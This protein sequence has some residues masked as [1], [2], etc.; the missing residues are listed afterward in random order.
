L[1]KEPRRLEGESEE[2][3]LL[4]EEL[5]RWLIEERRRMDW[6]PEEVRRGLEVLELGIDPRAVHRCIEVDPRPPGAEPPVLMSAYYPKEVAVQVWLPFYAYIFRPFTKGE[7]QADALER[8]G[9]RLGEY[10]QRDEAAR[11][12]FAVGATIT[13]TPKL[14]GFQFNPPNLTIELQEDWHRLEFKLRAPAE[15]AGRASNGVLTFTA[16]GVIIADVPISIY[17]GERGSAAEM[18]VASGRPYQ[19]IFCSYSH[20]DKRVAK[21]VEAVCK[22]LGFTYHR[23]VMMLRSGQHWRDEIRALIE[24]ADIFQLFWSRNA[25]R[26]AYVEEEWRHALGLGR[27]AAGFV[28]PVYWEEPIPPPPA[29][30][31]SLHF[32]FAPE[33][34]PWLRRCASLAYRCVARLVRHPGSG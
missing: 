9:R 20:R 2:R 6:P 7:V 28:R 16:E 24:R 10:R 27:N 26:S 13:A 15:L 17:V 23:D 8:L 33:L 4:R 29:E 32:A 30:L 31:K 25:A 1:I 21:R 3:R 19:A 34:S 5:S 12:P 18:A 14:D 22:A 11:Q